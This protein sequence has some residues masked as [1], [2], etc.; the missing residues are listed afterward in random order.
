MGAALGVTLVTVAVD[1]LLLAQ[2]ANNLVVFFTQFL[3]LHVDWYKDHP[4]VHRDAGVSMNR[5]R[6][7]TNPDPDLSKGHITQ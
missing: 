7:N 5:P 1:F 6:P 4:L 3:R 2:C